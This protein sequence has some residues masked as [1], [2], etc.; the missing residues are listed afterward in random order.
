MKTATEKL[1]KVLARAGLGS[2]RKIEQ[3][4]EQGRVTVDGRV[5]SL[6]ARV[7][8]GAQVAVDG[9]AVRWRVEALPTRVLVYHKPLG[10]VCTRSD[11]QGRPTIFDRLPPL[12]D[13]RW[14]SV[15]RLDLNTSGLLLLTN[16]GA[17][18]A[19]LMHPSGGVE[20][21]YLVR[22]LGRI[23]EQSIERLLCG[24]R[25]ADGVARFVRITALGKSSGS[26]RWFRVV[27]GEGRYREVRRL[28]EAVGGRVSRLKRTRF[29]PIELPR[30][31]RPGEYRDLK[32]REL[33]ALMETARV[34]PA[35]DAS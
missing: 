2:R 25:I 31:L 11:P 34:A 18:A 32:Q 3:W 24:V 20:R 23:D 9:H 17:L 4:I 10:E 6:G 27:L 28:W 8:A 7:G 22:V 5:A 12:P 30:A 26:N 15:G 13:G 1:H 35:R 33:D 14:I 16:D 21:E 29:G 19:R